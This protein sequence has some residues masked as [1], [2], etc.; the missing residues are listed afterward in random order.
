MD[1]NAP[2]VFV[3]LQKMFEKVCTVSVQRNEGLKV[4]EFNS[5]LTFVF[6]DSFNLF[7]GY[8]T[9]T[10]VLIASKI[11]GTGDIVVKEVFNRAVS[12]PTHS[13]NQHSPTCTGG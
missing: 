2:C 8:D 11:F 12:L 5:Q 4:K 13:N 7:I 9:V 6:Q 10:K 3:S 1:T